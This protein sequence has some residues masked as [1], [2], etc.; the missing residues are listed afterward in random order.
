[1]SF[2]RLKHADEIVTIEEFVEG[3]FCKYVNNDGKINRHV[4]ED[5]LQIIEC[6]AHYSYVKSKCNLLLVDIQGV[7]NNLFDPE[8]ATVG[9]SFDDANDLMFCMGNLS[10]VALNNFFTEHVCNKFCKVAELAEVQIDE[11]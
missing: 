1:M 7:K 8:I 4:D 5:L 11:V 10:S 9:G 3:D 2:G 6:L